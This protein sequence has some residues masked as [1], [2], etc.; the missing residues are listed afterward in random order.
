M[1][2]VRRY[3]DPDAPAS[4][5]SDVS[6]RSRTSATTLPA[7]RVPR[8]P[9]RLSNDL[10]GGAFAC[11]VCG[12]APSPLLVPRQAPSWLLPRLRRRWAVQRALRA[13]EARLAFAP[14]G[15]A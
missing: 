6:G 8:S 15:W 14:W 11:P 12:Q 7:S 13:S 10:G 2:P 4:P 5:G 9:S 3:P 1:V